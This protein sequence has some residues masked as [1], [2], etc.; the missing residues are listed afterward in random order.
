[1]GDVEH[2]PLAGDPTALHATASTLSRAG[3]ALEVADAGLARVR[4][5][6]ASQRGAAV[7]LA[8]GRLDDL[9]AR[10]AAHGAVLDAAARVLHG[11]ADL[12]H[13]RQLEAAAAIARRRAALDAVTSREAELDA[14]HRTPF[15]DTL[16]V[17]H[18][19]AS[20]T[21]SGAWWRRATTSAGPRRTGGPRATRSRR[22]PGVR[23]HASSRSPRYGP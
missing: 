11:Q 20:R 3:D 7:T 2:L 14:L 19:H 13:T 16:G 18:G 4:A 21:P 5:A 23:R 15:L 22:S 9:T 12:L 8:L 1:M 6:V 10:S 17:G